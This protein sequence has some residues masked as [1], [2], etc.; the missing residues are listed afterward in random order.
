LFRGHFADLS[1]R[2]EA[3]YEGWKQQHKPPSTLHVG[4]TIP[5]DLR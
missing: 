2:C 3:N 4:A 1:A 5:D